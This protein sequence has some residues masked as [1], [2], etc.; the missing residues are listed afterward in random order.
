MT[1]EYTLLVGGVVIRGGDEPDA[2][3]IAWAA[4]TV[5]AIG[6]DAEVRAI[7]RGD[8]H[9]SEL[10]GATVIPLGGGGE[11]RWPTDAT[12]E[13][14]GPADLAVLRVDPRAAGGPGSG[15]GPLETLALIRGGRVVTGALPA[16]APH[17]ER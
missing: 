15:D 14:G 9:F 17:R 12:L 16:A 11:P 2:T 4:D 5:L 10:L 1:H 7:S 3:A 13:V 8:S 6:S